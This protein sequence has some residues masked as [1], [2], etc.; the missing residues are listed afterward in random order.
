MPTGLDR[1][2]AEQELLDLVAFLRACRHAPQ[3][4]ASGSP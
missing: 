1:V 3:P 4:A 2:L